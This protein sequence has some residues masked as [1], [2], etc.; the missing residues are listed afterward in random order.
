LTI[1]QVQNS[2]SELFWFFLFLFFEVKLFVFVVN[3]ISCPEFAGQ[4]LSFFLLGQMSMTP[5]AR[6]T[7]CSIVRDLL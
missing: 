5:K 3:E 1:F 7:W 4:S 2:V 6:M